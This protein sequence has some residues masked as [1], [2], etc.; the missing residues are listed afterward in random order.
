MLQGAG[1]GV[2]LVIDTGRSCG[3]SYA[4]PR[5]A[6]CCDASPRLERSAPRWGVVGGGWSFRICTPSRAGF[7]ALLSSSG[8]GAGS[9]IY[10]L[11]MPPRSSSPG[12]ADRSVR[13]KTPHLLQV[14]RAAEGDRKGE[15]DV[16]LATVDQAVA[17]GGEVALGPTRATSATPR[18]VG[19]AVPPP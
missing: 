12:F 3:R 5:I 8:A 10:R 14:E 4:R 17:A 6:A 9:D 13:V 19:W 18:T 11:S 15:A 1:H 2:K 7:G 16:Q